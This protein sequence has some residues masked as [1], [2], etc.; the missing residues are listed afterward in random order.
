M[1]IKSMLLHYQVSAAMLLDRLKREAE[2]IYS[3]VIP[4][5]TISPG[6]RLYRGKREYIKHRGSRY[7]ISQQ[8][9]YASGCSINKTYY[10]YRPQPRRPNYKAGFSGPIKVK[11]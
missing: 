8:S 7:H 5:P 3:Y 9:L 1:P 6:R 2:I 4:S 11:E 10:P